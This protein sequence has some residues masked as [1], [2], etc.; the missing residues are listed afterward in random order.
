MTGKDLLIALGDISHKYYDEGENDVFFTPSGRKAFSRPVLIAAVLILAL[1]LVGCTVAYAQGW[2]VDF[3]S[4]RSEAPLDGEQIQYIEEKEQIIGAVQ[5][6][7]GWSV[8]L[9]SAMC[10]GHTGYAIFGVTA[11]EG[12]SL[13]RPED[14]YDEGIIPGNFGMKAEGKEAFYTSMGI[15]AEEENCIW[16]SSAGWAEDHDGLANTGNIVFQFWPEKLYPDR[17]MT[18]EDPFG[19][20]REFYFCFDQ[21]VHAYEDE[22]YRR[23]L[24]DAKYKGQSEYM[25]ESEEVERINQVEVLN[26]GLW[27]FTVCFDAKGQ[28]EEGLELLTQPIYVEGLVYHYTDAEHWETEERMEKVKV[29]SF[30]LSPLGATM[31]L[32]LEGTAFGVFFEW[33]Q[34]YGYGD[35][36]IYAIMKD[37]SQIPLHTQSVGYQLEAGTPI[38][39]SE[40]DHI[41]M[42]DGTVIPVA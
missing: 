14:S 21:F 8:E 36:Y 34:R 41:L 42:A 28:T 10:D 9:K 40:V 27:E 31:E 2:F 5:E 1:L 25:L 15:F 23:Y 6:K 33:Q 24:M 19:P 35:R 17:E 3:F 7:N 32:E 16:Q 30:I 29:T 26:D 20:E 39:L 38:I 18:L 37:G 22:E 4:G 12:V 11:P 13:E